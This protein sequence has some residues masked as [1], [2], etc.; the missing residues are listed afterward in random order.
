[1]GFKLPGFKL[2]KGKSEKSEQDGPTTVLGLNTTL[3]MK[4]LQQLAGDTG[5]TLPLIG[6]RPLKKQLQILG[7]AW[8]V[9]VF[10]S[11]TPLIWYGVNLSFLKQRTSIST[12]MQ[13]LSQRIAKG[14]QQAALAACRAWGEFQKSGKLA[15]L[16]LFRFMHYGYIL[17]DFAHFLSRFT[18]Y[19][20]NLDAIRPCASNSTRGTPA[21]I[22][23]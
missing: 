20:H 10:L 19:P 21:S 15:R 12:E 1:M 11:F 6:D 9:S 8:A 14:A 23:S 16:I 5:R 17:P 4:G 22:R 3:V 7:G 18:D 13:M 2:F